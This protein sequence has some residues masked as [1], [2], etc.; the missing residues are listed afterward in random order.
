MLLSEEYAEQ[1]RQEVGLEVFQAAELDATSDLRLPPE[2]DEELQALA[3]SLGVDVSGVSNEAL[4]KRLRLY[5]GL[6]NGKLNTIEVDINLRSDEHAYLVLPGVHW[7]EYETS[8]RQVGY[9]RRRREPRNEVQRVFEALQ[10]DP[11]ERI[12]LQTITEERL[13]SL[14]VG[15]LVI[16]NRRLIFD[17]NDQNRTIAL[18]DVLD[19]DISAEG[20]TIELPE[21]RPILLGMK[22]R[23]DTLRLL[24]ARVI[25]DSDRPVVR[26]S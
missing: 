8:T 7:Q 1:L 23:Q 9:Q 3:V 4:L 26:E 13:T 2:E 20:V 14:G 18:D 25:R 22:A 12:E 10:G 11:K 6:E 5:W 21:G 16:T 19:F 17:G 15:D 24:L